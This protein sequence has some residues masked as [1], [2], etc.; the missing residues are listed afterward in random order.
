[1]TFKSV[2]FKRSFG[3]SMDKQPLLKHLLWLLIAA[4]V[5][6]L[7]FV[8]NNYWSKYASYNSVTNSFQE[9]VSKKEQS[10]ADWVTDTVQLQNL[11]SG[12]T[13]PDLLEQIREK[14]FFVFIYKGGEVAKGPIFWSTNEVLPDPYHVS[15]FRTG[16]FVKYGSGQYE[17]LKRTMSTSNGPLVVVGLVL[18]HTEFFIE[19]G[20]LQKE[21]PGFSGLD[22][23]M[24]ITTNP[25]PYD[26]VGERGRPLLYFSPQV[27][28]PIYVFN[29]ASFI[30][31]CL[32]SLFLC[33]FI[34]KFSS[35]LIR[36]KKVMA[37]LLFFSICFFTL[38]IAILRYSFPIDLQQLSLFGS[39]K[40]T[41]NHQADELGH[42]ML[43]AV[44]AFWLSIFITR[45]TVY[46]LQYISDYTRNVKWLMTIIL[47]VCVALG[48]FVLVFVVR[49]LYLNSS[50]SFDLTN[51]LSFDYTTTLSLCIL[52]LLCVAHYL[53]VRFAVQALMRLTGGKMWTVLTIVIAAGLVVLTFFLNHP[54][55]VALLFSLV[56]LLVFFVTVTGRKLKPAPAA[57]GATIIWLF[58][59]AVSLSLLLS[60]LGDVKLKARTYSLGKSLQM[61]KDSTSEYLVRYA[62]SNLK[63]MDWF[64]LLERCANEKSADSLKKA[65]KT[66][67]FSDYLDKYNTGIYLFN[68]YDSSINNEGSV[69]FESLN[70]LTA[71]QGVS[72][73]FPGL[74]YFN[75]SFDR[76]GYI[77]K[78]RIQGGPENSFQGT[79]FVVVRSMGAANQTVSPELFRQLQDFAIDL[80]AGF[81]YGWYKNGIL[82]EQYRNYPFPSALPAPISR[83]QSFWENETND[84]YEI[85]M[86]AGSNMVITLAAERKMPVGFISMMAYLFGAFLLFYLLLAGAGFLLRGSLFS[87]HAFQHFTLTLQSKIR[88]TVIA[89][90]MAAFL[91]V[92]VVTIS[93]FIK[94]FKSANENKLSKTVQDISTEL[95]K[96]L[97][98][99]DDSISE[100]T[101]QLR[102]QGVLQKIAVTQNID[103]NCFDSSGKLIATTL[104]IVYEKGVISPMA[105]PLSWW[106][107]K[108]GQ[109]HRYISNERIGRLSYFSIYQVLRNKNNKVYAYLQVP[110][111][112]SQNEL[113]QEISN[114][115]VILI[116]IIAFVFLLSGSL[117]FWIS[118]SITRSFNI[119]AEKMDRIRLSERNERIE[120][121]RNDEIGHLVSQ[122][123]KMVDQLE[124]S[125]RMMARSERETAWREMA[126][127]VA[128]EIKNPLTPMKLSLQ[129][130]QKAINEN[131]ADVAQ[132]TARVAGNL[133]GQIDHLSNIATEFSQFANLGNVRP[134]LFDLQQAIREVIQLYGHHEKL[135]VNWNK[136]NH[137]QPILADRTQINRLFTNLFQNA[138]EAVQDDQPI[139]I[140]IGEHL[141]NGRVIISFTDNGK[142]IPDSV[143]PNIF[144]PNFT[145]KS[146]GTGLGLAICKAI[147]ENAG[148]D[149]WFETKADVGTTF[150]VSLP[151]AEA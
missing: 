38:R 98:N 39:D 141:E 37:G 28:E 44:L 10:F 74:F 67:Y 120:W 80:P 78:Q 69:N 30:V 93:F 97:A 144:V 72:T 34:S 57:S 85:W 113:K 147:V 61:Q 75:E 83:N 42:L 27:P 110:Y 117:A 23:K 12:N 121:T 151:V 89:I 40:N 5:Y 106:Y 109:L 26:I 125:A 135:T 31:E 149:I 139:Q 73:G 87:A 54:Y 19:N 119:I 101:L 41:I 70:T 33:L 126:R 11:A 13:K 90:L 123:N 132:V 102:L 142:G 18:L 29:R 60:M 63:R 130:L 47:A 94:Q 25:T 77:I 2:R 137:S 103:A 136:L 71:S 22:G 7:T 111:F 131:R 115:L 95:S 55:T 118:G 9:A 146:S 107:L 150:Y 133:V 140:T 32:A 43:D 84:A 51:F 79:L 16:S 91:I 14:P 49:N 145:T 128:H 138:V 8:F 134:E 124:E 59:Y 88:I 86:N 122:Y 50:I 105:D 68:K 66:T 52:F 58:V 92:A 48:H 4:W 62:A 116:N 108:H 96:E 65:I 20:S 127:Q 24:S 35:T 148:G 21:Y 112:S 104:D 56:W 6:T 143:Q 114:F 129:F 1:L 53:L 100:K 15:F 76:F 17:M 46:I 3:F 82:V 45:H 64:E 99:I 36:Q 81:S